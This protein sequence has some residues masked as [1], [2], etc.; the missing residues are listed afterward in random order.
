[1]KCFSSA[2]LTAFALGTLT[3]AGCNNAATTD[4]SATDS[5]NNAVTNTTT[6]GEEKLS[7]KPFTVGYNQWIGSVGVFTAK[8]KGFFKDAG[9]DVQMKQFSGPADS[10][11]PLISGKLDA[12][13]TTADTALCCPKKPA[14]TRFSTFLSPTRRMA[15]TRLWRKKASSR[16][17]I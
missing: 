8:E 16:S 7:G 1:M 10:V 14:I 3:L 13:L 2:F 4:N 12:S 9:L 6:T 11:P 17:K 5:A 15:R